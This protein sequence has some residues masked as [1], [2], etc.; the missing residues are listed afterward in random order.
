MAAISAHG[1][2]TGTIEAYARALESGAEFVEFDIRRT[3][4]ALRAARG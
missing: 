1:P 2:R 3:A 4:D